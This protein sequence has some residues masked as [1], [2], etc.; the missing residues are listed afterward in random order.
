MKKAAT[1]P[2]ETPATPAPAA[3]PAVTVEP[4]TPEIEV[5]ERP[6]APEEEAVGR[7]EGV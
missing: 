5:I 1:K 7:R 4:K 3:P 2:V 6:T